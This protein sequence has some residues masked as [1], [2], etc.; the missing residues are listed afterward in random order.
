MNFPANAPLRI[1]V[2]DDD[3][4]DRLAFRRHLQQSGIDARTEEASS[5]ADT[6]DMVRATAFD[7]I[8]LDYYIPGADTLKLLRTLRDTLPELPVV[9][10]TGRGD[11]DIAV[12]LM[13]SGAADYL[14]KSS[15]TPERLAS[16]LRHAREVTQAAIARRRAESLLRLLSQAAEH[17]LTASTTDDLVRGLF[18]KI[19][20][21]LGVDAFLNYMVDPSVNK[22]QLASCAGIPEDELDAVNEPPLDTSHA[23]SAIAERKPVHATSLQSSMEP[24]A[25]I[26]KSIGFRACSCHPLLA[27]YQLLGTLCFASRTK[28]AFREDELDFLRTVSHY[29]TA[30]FER[31]RYIQQMRE[32]DR[33]KDEFLATLA[34]ELRDPLAPL[35]NVLEL[36]KR[37]NGSDAILEQVRDTLDRQLSHLVQLVDDLLDMSRIT[38]N[39]LDL[40]KRRVE[41][42]PV[43]HQ[44]LDA[45]RP[46]AASFGHEL[47][48]AL[49][50]DPVFLNADPVRLTQVFGNLLTNAC[51]YTE[52][53]GHIWLSAELQENEVIVKVR[54]TGIGIPRSKLASVFD[55]FSQLP[56]ARDLSQGGLGIGLTLVKRLVVLHGGTVEAFSPGPG[57][58]TEFI[59]RLPVLSELAQ[60][61]TAVRQDETPRAGGRRILIVDDNR[62]SAASLAMLLEAAGNKTREAYDGMEALEAAAEFHPDVVLLDIGLPKLNGFEVCRRM[63]AEPWGRDMTILAVSGWGQDD[64]RRKSREAGFDNHMVKPVDYITLLKLLAE[65]SAAARMSGSGG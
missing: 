30:A 42:S 31:L 65:P 11:E 56:A 54:D 10:F 9:I 45:A 63:R 29:A 47:H 14:P 36:I 19:R 38:R 21:P 18:E 60:A 26:L 41:L 28:D 46:M 61:Q 53:G 4:L 62:D 20:E 23:G 51:K 49:P 7:C 13:K 43:I 59:I 57:Q 27:Q 3:E 1:L 22:L 24:S 16:A 39:R 64:D 5:T 52:P 8:F 55:M 2:V 6:L 17:I 35:S 34:H 44:A 33:R 50:S 37:A 12:E 15:L 48:V 25:K 32:D 58:G 40:R